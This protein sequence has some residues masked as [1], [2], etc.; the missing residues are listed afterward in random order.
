MNTSTYCPVSRTLGRRP[1]DLLPAIPYLLGYAPTD[2]LVCLFFD[3]G[4]G[5]RLSSRVDWDTCRAAPEDV[6]TTLS[7]R[8]ANT[9]AAS[10]LVVAVDP[11]RPSLAVIAELSALFLDHGLSI[12]WAG[13]CL[14]ARW[15]GLECTHDCDHH[16]L[17]PHCPTVLELI[18]EGNAPAADRAGIVA[19]VA[20][21]ADRLDTLARAAMPAGGT[22]R[23]V[24]RDTTIEDV[25]ALLSRHERLGDR[26]VAVVA[27]ACMDIRVRDVVLWRLTV[28]DV[29]VGIA[30]HRTWQVFSQTLRQAPDEAVAPVAAV[31]ALVAWQ[32]GEG[33]RAMECL[34]RARD[35]DPDHSLAALVFRCVDAAQPPSLWW[36]VMS[37]LDEETCRHGSHSL[38]QA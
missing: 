9:G 18:A 12:D 38:G 7:Q 28:A 24:W 10:V 37:G 19:E 36:Q 33:T 27:G 5:M 17:D 2:S 16:V 1:E 11:E 35:A 14:G 22:D 8:A 25:M 21:A 31:A 26:D 30:S 23:E 20:P 4:G 29:G 3:S 15:R 6:A 13:E 34:K 32:M